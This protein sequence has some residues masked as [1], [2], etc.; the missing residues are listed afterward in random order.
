VLLA[1]LCCTHIRT[2]ISSRTIA[3]QVRFVSCIA[4]VVCS[5]C[6]PTLC[7]AHQY[8]VQ[9][10]VAFSE[11]RRSTALFLCRD[12][13]LLGF[14]SCAASLRGGSCNCCTPAQFL[15]KHPS[16]FHMSHSSPGPC[17]HPCPPCHD[18]PCRSFAMRGTSL[19][20]RAGAPIPRASACWC[21][22][23]TEA[24]WK[25]RAGLG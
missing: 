8:F 18:G 25:G 12:V 13:S 21:C 11:E 7:I 1:G 15:L 2:V 16:R 14:L 24:R 6:S 10:L 22:M 23:R 19:E 5:C 3:L 20:A 4:I 17:A 9:E